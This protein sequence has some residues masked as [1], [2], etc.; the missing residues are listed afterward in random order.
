[1]IAILILIR[2]GL[3][4]AVTYMLVDRNKSGSVDENYASKTSAEDKKATVKLCKNEQSFFFIK[5]V[6]YQI[7]YH[8]DVQN[9]LNK[10]VILK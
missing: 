7:V 5:N 4:S 2:L 9:G 3:V 10:V 8:S 1:M 6:Q